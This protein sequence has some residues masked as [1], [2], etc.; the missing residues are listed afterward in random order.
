M[1]PIIIF[2]FLRRSVGFIDFNIGLLTESMMMFFTM[3]VGV[4]RRV[5]VVFFFIFWLNACASVET[6][7]VT[8][9]ENLPGSFTVP[10]HITDAGHLIVD[11]SINGRPAQPFIVDTGANVSAV[12]APYA[13][14]MELVKTENGVVVNG[15]V[16]TNI[17]PSL[18]AVVFKI[19]PKWF[20]PSSVILLEEPIIKNDAIGLLGLDVLSTYTVLFNRTTMMASFIQSDEVN[21]DT[22]A[23]W[24]KIALRNKV[25]SFP[26][27]GLYFAQVVLKDDPVPVL[28]D[29]GSDSNLVNWPL[30]TLD[31]EFEKVQRRLQAEMRLQGANETISVM[32]RTVF[33]DLALGN[34][35]WPEVNVIVMDFDSFTTIAPVDRPFMIA[36]APM[37][38][39]STF[40]F[41]FAGNRLYIYPQ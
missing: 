40:A 7:P 28:I 25:G 34:K 3:R 13:E 9:I 23:G 30:A 1:L 12:Y 5:F 29:T 26:D 27:N 6:A 31:E 38:T 16:S 2:E 4:L 20:L 8:Q 24:K 22:F 32:M 10:Y 39:P 33:F 35:K 21:A 11:I 19:G 18:E 37:F 36:G 14:A 17:R 41:D 15:L